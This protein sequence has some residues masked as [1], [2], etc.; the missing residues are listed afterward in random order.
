VLNLGRLALDIAHRSVDPLKT[1]QVTAENLSDLAHGL[2]ACFGE[3]GR[4][5]KFVDRVDHLLERTGEVVQVGMQI[6]REHV[7]EGEGRTMRK[8]KKMA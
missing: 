1:L 6:C 5:G 7:A 4:V 2:V 3:F 8:R